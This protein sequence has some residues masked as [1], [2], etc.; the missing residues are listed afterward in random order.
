[1]KS[2]MLKQGALYSKLHSLIND[3]YTSC[4][5]ILCL[6]IYMYILN[7]RY[8]ASISQSARIIVMRPST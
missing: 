2:N 7:M 6:F 5:M 8:F 3:F 4:C 1:M